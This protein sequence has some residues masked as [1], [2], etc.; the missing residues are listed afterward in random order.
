MSLHPTY[1]WIRT[2]LTRWPYSRSKAYTSRKRT[3][4]AAKLE[5]PDERAPKRPALLEDKPLH[6]QVVRLRLGHR[7]IR[8]LP[9]RAEPERGQLPRVLCGAKDD[10]LFQ[11]WREVFKLDKKVH[12][13]SQPRTVS[14]KCAREKCPP[15]RLG[16]FMIRGE[17]CEFVNTTC[18]RPEDP[19]Q[20]DSDAD[21]SNDIDSNID[22]E[23]G[24][25]DE[26]STDDS[27]SDLDV[28]VEDG[29]DS[30]EYSSNESN[31]EDSSDDGYQ[32]VGDVGED[33]DGD[34]DECVDICPVEA[35]DENIERWKAYEFVF[36]HQRIT[37]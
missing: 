35:L 24:T 14:V 37:I 17:D 1:I 22:Y 10:N 34:D 3:L 11:R 18:S 2:P 4:E 25:E 12:V 36:N 20:C 13:F 27:K 26:F 5:L 8:R 6:A 7:E 16:L 32:D 19:D 33:G 23:T 9:R 21:N 28:E 15:S 29:A 30:D 31:D